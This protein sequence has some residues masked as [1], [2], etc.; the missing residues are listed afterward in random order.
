MEK[1]EKNVTLESLDNK[2]DSLVGVV[3]KLAV[4]MANGFSKVDTRFDQI[5]SGLKSFKTETRENFDKLGKDIK[6]NKEGIEAIVAEYHPHI[7]KLEEK[8]FGNS[9]LAE[10]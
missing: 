7:I 2:I 3:D 6:E 9:T 5:D 8:V 1:E 10:V 4:S